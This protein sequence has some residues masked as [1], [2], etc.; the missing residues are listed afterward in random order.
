MQGEM[1]T[2]FCIICSRPTKYLCLL[3]GLPLCQ[4]CQQNGKCDSCNEIQENDDDKYPRVE[5]L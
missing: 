4:A 1:K 2:L 5:N 3:C